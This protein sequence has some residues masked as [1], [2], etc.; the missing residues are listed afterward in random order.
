MFRK[1]NS[2]RDFKT[3]RDIYYWNELEQDYLLLKESCFERYSTDPEDF[4]KVL[5]RYK[6]YYIVF[7]LFDLFVK[8]V[9]EF[10]VI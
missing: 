7:H 5:V 6:E 3:N 2:Y 10:K 8:E 1:I 9:Y 4:D